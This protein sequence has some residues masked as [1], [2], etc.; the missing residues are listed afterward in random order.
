MNGKNEMTINHATMIEAV[1][2]YLDSLFRDG[3]APRVDSVQGDSTK[4]SGNYYFRVV[5]HGAED[6]DGPS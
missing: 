1:Q 6:P 4:G 5:T 2:M 3:K